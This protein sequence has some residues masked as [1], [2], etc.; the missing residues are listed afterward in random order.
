MTTCD[1]RSE[2]LKHW[3]RSMQAHNAELLEGGTALSR[4]PDIHVSD[5]SKRGPT[6]LV[7]DDDPIIRSVIAGGLETEG[8]NVVEAEDGIEAST[9]CDVTTPSLAIVDAMMPNMDGFE[10]C[11]LLRRRTATRHVPILM[12]TGLD[13]HESVARAYEAGATDFIAKPLNWL[14]LYHRIRYMLRG[15]NA[16]AELRANQDRLRAV[17]RLQRQQSDRLQAALANMSQGLCMF[18]AD[19]RLIVANE[20]YQDIFQLPQ[21]VLA[22]GRSMDEILRASPLLPQ[23]DSGADDAQF[24][25]HL[26]LSSSRQSAALTLEL[27]NGRVVTITHEPMSDGGFV[28]TVTDVTQQRMD[29][30]RIVHMAL[31]DPLTDLPNRFLF[32]QRLETA[33]ERLAR[34]EPCAVFCLDLE[35]G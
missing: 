30:A 24:R 28:D 15:A 34:G 26:A 32:R 22:P 5:N 13:D 16:L 14:I 9:I 25:Q 7:V 8:F 6:I 19:N 23:E 35:I 12:A 2:T 21:F 4:P 20:R 29:E 31:H 11:Q 3:W 27:T 1:A 10:L 17:Q 18:G 33:L